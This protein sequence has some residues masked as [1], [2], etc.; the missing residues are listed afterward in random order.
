MG[1]PIQVRW[2]ICIESGS[3]CLCHNMSNLLKK[4]SRVSS[5]FNASVYAMSL[6]CMRQIFRIWS[7]IHKTR[8][9]AVFLAKLML[10][11]LKCSRSVRNDWICW[12]MKAI[13]LEIELPFF[14][15]VNKCIDIDKLVPIAAH[16]IYIYIYIYDLPDFRP[17]A[18]RVTL[19]MRLQGDASTRKQEETKN[20]AWWTYMITSW[21]GKAFR[22]TASL[23]WWPTGVR[24]ISQTKH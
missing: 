19:L 1:L 2:H 9:L 8:K 17:G 18:S 6:L 10:K 3:W 15:A 14:G 13:A 11:E 7:T 16:H 22:I 20:V 23:W 5:G 12:K 24:W 21:R 4:K